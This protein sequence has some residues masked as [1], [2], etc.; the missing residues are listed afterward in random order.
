MDRVLGTSFETSLRILLLLDASN[1][2]GMTENMLCALD[3][4]IVYAHD[5]G[6]S[7]ENLHAIGSYRFGEF[8]SRRE[9]TRQALKQLVVDG[10]AVV[11]TADYGF[12]YFI[13]KSG[14]DYCRK[15][16]TVYADD[17]RLSA[18]EALSDLKGKTEEYLT[19]MINQCTLLSL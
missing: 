1:G 12:A 4:I 8:A 17:Y 18:R 5:F 14:K 10:F 15:F 3:F 19:N 11:K 16:E 7:N 9:L 6:I 2:K 13:S